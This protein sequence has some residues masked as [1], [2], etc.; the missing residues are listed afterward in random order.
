[1]MNSL[2]SYFIEANLYLVSFY[3]LYQLLLARDRHFRFNRAFLLGGVFLSMILPLMSF[4]LAPGAES[5]ESFEGYIMLPAITIS[6]VQTESVGL[7]L[8]WWHIIGIIYLAGV[9]FYLIRLLWQI[10]QILRHLPFLNSTREQKAGYT[11][12]TTNGDI[13]TCSF[14]KFL[15]WDKSASLNEDEKK[16]IL[17]HELVHIRQWHSI[18]VLIIELLRAIFWFNPVVHLLKSRLTE[19]HE[20]LAD[21][22]ATKQIDVDSYSKLLT[23]QVFKSFDF[24]LSNNFHKSQIIKRFRML[25]S[26]RSRSIWINVGLLAPSLALLITVL[27]CDVT[28]MNE[29]SPINENELIPLKEVVVES[30]TVEN[31]NNNLTIR[32]ETILP[33][34]NLSGA[35][36]IFTIVED[37]PT[38]IGGMTAFYEYVQNSLKYPLEAKG[39]EIEGKVFVQFVVDPDGKLTDVKSVKGIGAGC[40]EEAIRVIG[41]SPAWNPGLQ[42]GRR[43]NVRMIMPITF[44]LN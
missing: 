40:D 14:F 22:Y 25:K 39:R 20:Y 9:L 6:N 35:N 13:P 4:N 18:D 30:N 7:I 8:K 29:I 33:D 24:A 28:E 31:L 23:L 1:M 16:L 32:E 44:K 36:E 43:V 21:H 42:R 27:A 10:A 41:E 12:V 37:Q 26:K 17:E 2:L 19:V 34:N 3:L 5:S 11:L 38:P 15:L